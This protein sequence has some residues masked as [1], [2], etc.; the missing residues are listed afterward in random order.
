MS[1]EATGAE[2]GSFAGSAGQQDPDSGPGVPTTHPTAPETGVT[3][4]AEGVSDKSGS[5]GDT[6]ERFPPPLEA[7]GEAGASPEI[8]SIA[9]ERDEYRDALQ[10]LQADFENYR[11]RVAKQQEEVRERAAE[12][13]V[14]SL[15]P[16]L[17]TCDLALSHGGGEEI[18]QLSATLFAVLE[19][20]GLEKID[21]AGDPFD[22][23]FHDAVAHDP[24]E[25]ESGGPEVAEVMRA[26]YRWRGRVVRPAMVKVRG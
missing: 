21:T 11:K 17:D 1:D 7:K 4:A 18:K 15:L 9:R 5:G 24:G 6:A 23:T 14:T 10:R 8:A 16:V 3:G 25:S 2:S 22:P 12:A 13:L 26:G 19:K 20:E